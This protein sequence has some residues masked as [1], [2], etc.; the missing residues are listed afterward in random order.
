MSLSQS[1]PLALAAL[2]LEALVGYPAPLY[3][4]VRPSRHLDGRLAR[5]ARGAAQPARRWLRR[6]ARA[7]R[8]GAGRSILRRSRVAA[9]AATRLL[10][11][12]GAFGFAALA[13]AGREPAGAA[14]PAC[15]C[16][17]GRRRARQ[18][19]RGGAA[20]GLD[21]RR[22]QPGRPRRSGRRA[23]RD[24]ESRGEFLRR[25]GRAGLLDR[26]RRARRRGALQGGQHRRQ[27]DRPQG[28]ALRRLRLGGGAARRSRQPARLPPRR[29]VAR[30]RRL[31]D[32]AA[33]RPWRRRAPF[34]G[35]PQNTARPT[36]A[37][38]KPRWPARSA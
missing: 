22:T 3:R 35:T 33:P 5:L 32:A 20:R 28:R 2:M 24:R 13:A 21:D 9:L 10:A 27:H 18:K 7:R 11:P 23:R 14:Q 37:G 25:R 38:R 26:A 34:G 29:A 8:A 30:S 19:P 16:A 4:A 12:L 31:S 36:P 15:P 6:A 17:R 1:L